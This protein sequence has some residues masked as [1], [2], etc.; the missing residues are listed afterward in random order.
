MPVIQAIQPFPPVSRRA[1]VLRR[2]EAKIFV[3]LGIMAAAFA[4]FVVVFSLSSDTDI[5]LAGASTV[6]VVFGVAVFLVARPSF[7]DATFV[8]M[9]LSLFYIVVTPWMHVTQLVPA[10]WKGSF[11]TE[12]WNLLTKG[13]LCFLAGLG[14]YA[15]G[16]WACARVR[17]GPMGAKSQQLQLLRPQVMPRL[18]TILMI[19]GVMGWVVMAVQSGVSLNPWT[20]LLGQPI[21][22]RAPSRDEQ[23]LGG[24]FG[25]VLELTFMPCLAVLVYALYRPW[26]SILSPQMVALFYGVVVMNTFYGSRL[27]L[28]AAP[29]SVLM[30]RRILSDKVPRDAPARLARQKPLKIGVL[31]L[32]A[33][34]IV[35][36][37][38]AIAFTSYR[39]STPMVQGDS[40]SLIAQS[41]NMFD[42]AVTYYMVLDRVPSQVGYWN[43]ASILTPLLLRIPR[44]VLPNKYEMLYASRRFVLLFY[45]YDQNLSGTVARGP[46]LMAETYINGGVWAVMIIFFFMGLGN[47]YMSTRV[48][49]PSAGNLFTVCY[50]VYLAYVLP[51]AWK[52]GI[53]E[54][55]VYI[56]VRLIVL[57]GTTFCLARIA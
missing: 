41:V 17:T 11:L 5:A 13:N 38:V 35:L 33:L 55:I 12:N 40:S 8:F 48:K 18:I 37:P 47:E 19:F 25:Y 39:S 15:V 4:S 34:V 45:G 14:A 54:G 27:L 2:A 1:P 51:F 42:T 22:D 21:A 20:I 53:T 26:K 9:A 32:A 29:I 23:F 10:G 7:A 44:V 56:D 28:V 36:F 30:L 43:G 31:K 57:M 24:G 50:V 46:N 3:L 16:M 6:A 49:M 52:C